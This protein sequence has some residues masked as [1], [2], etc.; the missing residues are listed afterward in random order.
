MAAITKQANFRL[1][2]NH[3]NIITSL[4]ASEH[5]TKAAVVEH[6]LELLEARVN[7]GEHIRAS[8][9]GGATKQA[10]FRLSVRHVDIID[11]L[12]AR[13]HVTKATV[14]E[15]ALELAQEEVA[16]GGSI[17]SGGHR[18]VRD[19]YAPAAVDGSAALKVAEP[20]ETPV[21]S[22]VANETPAPAVLPEPVHV[23]ASVA[24]PAPASDPASVAAPAP[25]AARVPEPSVQAEPKEKDEPKSQPKHEQKTEAKPEPEAGEAGA[26]ERAETGSKPSKR[27]AARFRKP[28]EES[29][30]VQEPIPQAM[31]EA[32][33]QPY[34]Y[35]YPMPAP[36]PQYMAPA[37]SYGAPAYGA[38]AFPAPAQ[39][40]APAPAAAP[41]KQD[42]E[43]SKAD[44]KAAVLEERLSGQIAALKESLEAKDARIDALLK[45]LDDRKQDGKDA[46]MESLIAQIAENSG[47]PAPVAQ[48]EPAPV[49]A[50][51]PAPAP[52]Q[53]N[54]PRIDM[55]LQRLDSQKQ[56]DPRLDAILSQLQ[57]Q[58]QD[59]PR[60]DAILRQLD[61][62]KQDDQSARLEALIRELAAKNSQPAAPAPA[63]VAAPS[64]ND[65]ILQ[66]IN[67]L[68]PAQQTADPSYQIEAARNAGREEGR[69]AGMEEGRNAGREEG[70][71]E[72]EAEVNRRLE[73]LRREYERKIEVA[74]AEGFE[75]G[76]K[77]IGA[78]T[79][80]LLA[81]A[82]TSGAFYERAKIANMRG[83]VF[84][85]K[86]RYLKVHVTM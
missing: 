76:K 16:N 25:A 85:E 60:I 24:G 13:E 5:V 41:A 70:R 80:K 6:A 18:A 2:N 37:A 46:R 4:S 68:K 11:R 51:Q 77:E 69:R 12:A 52:Q 86:R 71:R 21:L 29:V 28:A 48:P 19:I 10:N 15:R 66:I 26:S 34:P 58:K 32:A 63:P 14:V 23:A 1:S 82:R 30:R 53:Q 55:I 38:H 47:K 67:A 43:I 61:S 3:V 79:E 31:P 20:E 54:D 73:D 33:G 39:M 50:P 40:P 64:R 27:K 74:R 65:E 56:Q 84:G 57:S 9:G 45:E 83:L 44:M 59:D 75:A 17:S 81:E 78:D 72:A 7:A 8:R 42:P 62:Q 22:Y 36:A 49:P 35:A